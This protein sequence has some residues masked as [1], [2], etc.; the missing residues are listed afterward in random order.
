LSW[1]E[2]GLLIPLVALMIYM[3]VYPRPFLSRSRESVQQVRA[4]VLPESGGE[5]AEETRK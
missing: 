4:R 3:G 5:V 1:R 2:I